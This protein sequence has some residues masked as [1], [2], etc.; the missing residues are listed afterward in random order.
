MIKQHIKTTHQVNV[1][2]YGSMF[3]YET[4]PRALIFRRDQD[5]VTDM[6]ALYKLMRSVHG[7]NYNLSISKNRHNLLYFKMTLF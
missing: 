2:K 4:T 6:D 7:I 3:A 1:D 5:K